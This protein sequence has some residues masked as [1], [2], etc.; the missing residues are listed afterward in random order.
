M[1]AFVVLACKASLAVMLVAA[2][3]AKLADVKGFAAT[4][5]LFGPRLPAGAVAGAIV[6]GEIAAGAA[7][8]SLPGAGWLNPVVL[9]ICCCF[10]LAWT[11]GYARHAGRPCRCFGALSRRGFTAGGIGR[12]AGLVLAAAVAAAGVPPVTIQLSVLARLGLLAGGALVA[13][14]AFSAAAAAGA[15]HGT[16]LWRRSRST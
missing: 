5:R 15:R 13:A 7:S 14:A 1:P 11:V 6:A 16:A 8:L 4:V 12:A 10:L 3:G 2:G 9:V